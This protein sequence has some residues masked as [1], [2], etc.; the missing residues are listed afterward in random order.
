VVPPTPV[1]SGLE[2]GAWTPRTL[3][4]SAP[5]SPEEAKMLTCRSRA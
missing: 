5:S 3:R 4:V 2:A 1:T